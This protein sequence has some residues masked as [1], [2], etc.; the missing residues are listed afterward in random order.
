MSDLLHSH[1]LWY[2]NRG[3]GIVLVAVLTLSV[4]LG[5]V[6][7]SGRGSRRW[8]RFAL[9]TLHRNVSVLAVGLL[10]AHAVTP[11]LDTYVNHY[12]QISWLDTVVPF[13]SH[14]QPLALGLGA[15]ALDLLVVVVLTSAA[16]LRFGRRAWYAVH[17]SSYAAWGLGLLHGF[18]V[19]SDARTVWGLGVTAAAVVVVAAAGVLR[20][21]PA[22]Q[23]VPEAPL[24]A[25][26]EERRP[27]GR[28]AAGR[29]AEV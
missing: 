9:Q 15:L 1:L 25:P 7:A 23:P 3:T 10:V 29:R 24:E 5:V 13:V 19:G 26:L 28:R 6:S 20:L 4:V 27:T 2:L 18:L 16:R 11:V 17:L 21:R 12:A 14:Y 22:P 8:P